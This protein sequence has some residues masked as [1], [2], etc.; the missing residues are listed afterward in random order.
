MPPLVLKDDTIDLVKLFRG[1]G[2]GQ[3]THFR[4]SGWSSGVALL[5]VCRITRALF[6]ADMEKGEL[7]FS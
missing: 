3:S 7:E 2:V 1:Q 5:S 4:S 6:L